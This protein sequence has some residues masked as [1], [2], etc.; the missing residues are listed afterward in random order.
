M[1]RFVKK[2]ILLGLPLLVACASSMV[3]ASP[4]SRQVNRIA[5]LIASELQPEAKIDLFNIS[6]LIVHLSHEYKVDPLLV[7]A[8]IKV[9]SDF[10]PE[11]RSNVGAIGLM[12]LMPIVIREVG[13]EV[14]VSTRADLYNPYKNIRLGVHYFTYLRDKYRNNLEYTLM[15]YN[16]GPTALDDLM[17]RPNTIPT[18]Y[19]R[20]VMKY[21]D[22]YRKKLLTT[23]TP[24]E[25]T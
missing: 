22:L 25:L 15:A 18:G 9:E 19:Y 8:I 2:T 10:K 14:S 1:M 17:T 12:Q 11:A 21:Y 4:Y 6:R 23:P 7:M 20:K 13:E 5:T 3:W 24:S 16:I